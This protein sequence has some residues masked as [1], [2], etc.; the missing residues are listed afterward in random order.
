MFH[1]NKKRKNEAGLTLIELLASI[2]LISIISI[3]LF[4]LITKAIENNNKIHAETILRDEADI[5]MS[6]VIKTLYST[7]QGYIIRNTTNSDN[8]FLEVTSDIEKCERREDG[9]VINS[10]QCNPTL[11]PIGFKTVNRTTS[12]YILDEQ[13]KTS[14]SNVKILPTSKVLGDPNKTSVYEITLNLSLTYKRG[15]I[16]QTKEMTFINQIE[17]ILTSK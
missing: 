15:N 1:L 7:K 11:K 4:S 10:N 16:E 8:S 5:I 6:K 17:P 2:A 3:L 9:S 14:Y 12:L 13:Y